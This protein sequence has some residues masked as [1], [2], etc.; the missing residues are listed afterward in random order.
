M[1]IDVT[2]RVPGMMVFK[3]VTVIFT[4]LRKGQETR[5]ITCL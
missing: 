4:S 2:L 1:S 3:K 5:T